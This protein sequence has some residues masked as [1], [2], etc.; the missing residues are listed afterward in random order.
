MYS[1]LY[2]HK[3]RYIDTRPREFHGYI[4]HWNGTVIGKKGNV[5]KQ[6]KRPRR[7]GGF[8]WC[9]RLYYNGKKKKWTTS[10]LIGACFFGN[11]D[12]MEM[13][14]LDRIPSNTYG[15]N[16]EINTKSEN[17]QH[18]RIDARRTEENKIQTEQP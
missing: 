7:G 9:V 18:W 8:D 2:L 13:N 14:H 5:L 4:V 15:S 6:E 16:L 12:G 3:G 10:R 1:F 11:I 17:Q